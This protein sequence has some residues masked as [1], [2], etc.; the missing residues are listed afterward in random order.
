MNLRVARDALIQ[1]TCVAPIRCARGSPVGMHRKQKKHKETLN[2][3]GL[4]PCLGDDGKSKSLMASLL[5]GPAVS[6]QTKS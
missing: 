6:S 2:K 5:V 4:S 3:R 1:G